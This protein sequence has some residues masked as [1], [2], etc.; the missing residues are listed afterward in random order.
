MPR[1]SAN[2]SIYIIYMAQTF[3]A[4]Y[5][6]RSNPVRRP[7]PLI[8]QAGGEESIDSFWLF[9]FL[10]VFR[11]PIE[12]PESQ[13]LAYQVTVGL[14]GFTFIPGSKTGRYRPRQQEGVM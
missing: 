4:I 5:I 6:A 12:M 11:F 1:I 2:G 10:C 13:P 14:R 9:C 8:E 7:Y 3:F